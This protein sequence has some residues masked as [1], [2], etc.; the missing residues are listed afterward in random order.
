MSKLGSV[1]IRNQ[2]ASGD[3]ATVA[4]VGDDKGVRSSEALDS[5][6][7]ETLK[8]LLLETKKMRLAL[9]I[10]IDHEINEGDLT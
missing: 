9:E 4:E 5:P 6:I 10:L 2:P 8:E 3:T 7:H 1:S